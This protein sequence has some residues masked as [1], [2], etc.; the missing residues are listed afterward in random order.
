MQFSLGWNFQQS[1]STM[2]KEFLDQQ[3]IIIH[4]TYQ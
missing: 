3:K 1:R 2:N 4:N